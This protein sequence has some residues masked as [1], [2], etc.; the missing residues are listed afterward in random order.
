MNKGLV[1]TILINFNGWQDTVACLESCEGLAYEPNRVL[2]VDNGSTND[3]VAR[4]RGRFPELSLVETGRNLGFA[5]GNNAGIRIAMEAGAEFV[6][7][8]NNDTVVDPAA[9][10][11]LVAAC[12]EDD[13]I[14]IVGSKI[15]YMDRPTTLWFA[16]GEISPLW[17]WTRHRGEGGADTVQRSVPAEVDFITGC[18]LLARTDVIGR[19]GPM[20]EDLFL[21]W[22]D[23]EWCTRTRKGGW[24]ILYAPASRVWH[25]L[26]ASTP[27]EASAVRWRYE[28]RNRMLYWRDHDRGRVFRYALMAALQAA[29][30]VA[31][32]GQ[33]RNGVGLLHGVADGLRGKSGWIA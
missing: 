32:K 5:G 29:Y 28:G 7:L 6:W 26:G 18:S 30:L 20:R 8:L 12:Q 13:A 25:K 2:V 21:Y 14:G 24:K 10:A 9:L 23:V 19:S 4:L 17:G 16:G 3:S 31:I 33:A 22:E 15:H 11:E 27:G 1:Y